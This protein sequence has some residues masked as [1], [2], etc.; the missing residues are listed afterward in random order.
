MCDCG[1]CLRQGRVPRLSQVATSCGHYELR[2]PN[3]QVTRRRHRPGHAH[4]RRRQ[5]DD[6]RRTEPDVRLRRAAR[7]PHALHLHEPVVARDRQPARRARRGGVRDR[8]SGL[9]HCDVARG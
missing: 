5:R 7:D 9:R 3:S 4:A 1:G 6:S 2:R 8:G